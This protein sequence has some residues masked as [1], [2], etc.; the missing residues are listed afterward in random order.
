MALPWLIG[1]LAIVAGKAIYDAV[2]DDSS[3]SS[4]DNSDHEEDERRREAEEE[5]RQYEREKKL[6]AA[7]IS[8]KDQG[9]IF[10]KNLISVLPKNIIYINDENLNINLS[11]LKKDNKFTAKLASSILAGFI[12]AK[13]NGALNLDL[14]DQDTIKKQA[15]SLKESIQKSLSKEFI[16]KEGFDFKNNKI[17]YEKF[18][19]ISRNSSL[20]DVVNSLN[21]IC[22]K[23]SS[24]EEI[25]HSL[26]IFS[27]VYK[28]KFEYSQDLKKI[29]NHVTSLD[30]QIESLN[31]IKKQ[32]LK[33]KSDN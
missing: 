25:L 5:R 31:N 33:L 7:Q 19:A 3:S 12:D 16:K 20:L 22:V 32:L 30:K 21:K 11:L 24:L 4:C 14:S 10:G 13:E 1:G 6:E 18:N 23:T 15:T 9:A 8:F 27:E 28:P 29:E 17:K 26:I 2:K